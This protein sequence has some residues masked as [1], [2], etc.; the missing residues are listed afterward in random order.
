LKNLGFLANF[1]LCL[2][3]ILQN[4]EKNSKLGEKGEAFT[5]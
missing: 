3:L 1:K 2:F 4:I 5:R